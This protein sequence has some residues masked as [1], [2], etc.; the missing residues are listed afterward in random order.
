MLM[1]AQ[2]CLCSCNVKVKCLLNTQGVTRR[3]EEQADRDPKGSKRQ[4]HF[5]CHPLSKVG[6]ESTRY[7]NFR[8]LRSWMAAVSIC[9]T[10]PLL[11]LFKVSQKILHH[12]LKWGTIPKQHSQRVT[13][14][15]RCATPCGVK[16]WSHSPKWRSNLYTNRC[17]ETPKPARWKATK[18]MT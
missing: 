1:H 13:N 2:G 10:Y 4:N 15:A 18:E 9:C 8:L 12:T 11:S 16:S 7:R 14:T 5:W 3:L 17:V 6:K